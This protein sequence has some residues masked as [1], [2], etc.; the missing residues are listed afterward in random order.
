[1][2]KKYIMPGLA[3]IGIIIAIIY[4]LIA[5]RPD[6]VAKPIALPAN[7][8]FAAYISGSGIIEANTE[9]IAIG[10]EISGIVSKIAVKVGSVVKKG[11]LLF[12]ID[13][14]DANAQLALAE[15]SFK[16][17]QAAL[18][19]VKDQLRMV[20][21]VKDKR[22]MSMD[23]INRKRFLVE[24]NAAKVET[25][26]ATILAAK[27]TLDRLRVV[28]PVD[29][30]V[31]K[32][33]VRLGEYAPS[34]VLA[35]PLI[36]FGN[37]DPMH[38]RIDIDEN[39]AWRFKP[40]AKGTASL[41]GNRDIHTPITFAYIEPYATPKVSLT[42]DSTERV[43]TRVL[44]VIYAYDRASMNAYAGQQVDVYIE[45]EPL[46]TDSSTEKAKP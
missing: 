3:G 38:V 19:D 11:D 16:E 17:A 20:E 36:T 31:M 6:P 46:P 15:A 22:A 21:S 34:G 40:G 10:T 2:N 37:L 44:Q 45:A 23:E 13:D 30:E 39:D 18:S 5:A 4:V 8:T 1:M 43:D 7:T 26:K 32:L 9:N 28:A 35:S 25:A 24:E 12:K 29:G 14:R 27:T 42:G 33:N 41:R